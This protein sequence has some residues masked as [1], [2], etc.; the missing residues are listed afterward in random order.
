MKVHK[1]LAPYLYQH[2]IEAGCD[3]AGRGCLAG[4]VFAAAVILPNDFYHPLLNDSKQI[5]EKARNELRDYIEQYATSWSV[6]KITP[7]E[8]DKIN[9]L[10]ASFKAMHK[11]IKSLEVKPEFLLI[12]GNRFTPYKKIPF[13]CVI[14]G[15]GK[16]T[17]IAAASILAKTHRDEYMLKLHSKF[18][19]FQW[20]TNKGYPTMHH[21][22][23]VL[24]HGRSKHHRYTFNVSIQTQM[25]DKNGNISIAPTI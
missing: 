21:R 11:A 16:F 22:K 19:Q 23:A 25:F 5:T 14:K 4:P 9:I 13:E 2:K 12:D 10:N 15:D 24:L 8:I 20:N 18:P 6:A 7:K 1:H 17:A 3:E